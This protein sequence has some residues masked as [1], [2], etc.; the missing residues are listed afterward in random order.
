MKDSKKIKKIKRIV[1]KAIK[2]FKPL[3]LYR[4]KEG[5]GFKETKVQGI[6]RLE[7]NFYVYAKAIEKINEL[8]K[9]GDKNRISTR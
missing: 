4:V 9:K 5:I 3:K 8:V 2:D 6:R 7:R 1:D